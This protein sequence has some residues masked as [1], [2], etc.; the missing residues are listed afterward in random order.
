MK[1]L[2][3]IPEDARTY[4]RTA[5]C[6]NLDKNKNPTTYYT[7]N[8][9]KPQFKKK[10]LQMTDYHKIRWLSDKLKWAKNSLQ[11]LNNN[12]LTTIFCVN[13]DINSI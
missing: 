11:M 7:Q 6:I 9:A 4:K 5:F 1:V 12:I 8:I 13:D 2:L 10:V 3:F